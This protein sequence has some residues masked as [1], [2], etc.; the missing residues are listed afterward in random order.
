VLLPPAGVLLNTAG[1]LVI[2]FG[3]LMG[4]LISDIRFRR[5]PR[6]EGEMLLS[7]TEGRGGGDA[8]QSDQTD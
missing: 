7:Q 8:D 6:P 2:V 4:N 1:F 3:I 5:R